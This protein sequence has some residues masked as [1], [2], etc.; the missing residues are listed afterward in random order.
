MRERGK[1]SNKLGF[2]LA[3]AGSAVGLGNI[4]RFPYLAA[5]YG[6]MFLLTYLVLVVTFGFS[7]MLTEFA[8]GR[9]TGSS[10]IGAFAALGKK[11]SF[12]GW[13]AVIVVF[14]IFPYYSVIG[15]WVTK[16]LTVFIAG[17]NPTVEQ[18]EAF[19]NSYVAQPV[20]PIVWQILFVLVTTAVVIR[21][22]QKG[23]EVASKFMM[24]ILIILTIGVAIY[25]VCLPGAMEG[26]K[27]YLI[28]DLSKMSVNMVLA[29]MGQ[30]FY[31]M[32][33]AMGIMITYGSYLSKEEDLEKSVGHVEI[34]DTGVAIL[35][36][37]MVIPAVFAFS[38]AETL[39]QGPSLMFI[40]LPQV[41]ASMP[42]GRVIGAVFFLLVLFA[43]LTSSISIMEALVSTLCDRFKLNRK[44]ACLIICACAI[45]IGVAPSL[46]FGLWSNVK[47]IGLGILDFMDFITNSVLMPV[48]ALLTCLFVGY[49]TGV[50]TVID[51]VELSSKFRRKKMY[52]IVV[53]YVA[54]IFILA[55]LISSVLNTFGII[56]L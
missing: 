45:V 46:G 28:P 24:P 11:Y 26:V 32:S 6:G 14:I 31:S 50:K 53:K 25:S 39:N 49:V 23:I 37:F 1:F 56:T 55:I 36:G 22:V 21:G 7:I 33:L 47:I 51:E 5:N 4:W 19:F 3:A 12:I 17:A 18:S 48:V 40:T 30:M 41:F 20:E 10:P 2:V 35:A 9:K 16:Y 42:F 43:A 13:L 44:I 38:G 34:F 27:Y 29:A 54:P 15:G 8:I 52:V